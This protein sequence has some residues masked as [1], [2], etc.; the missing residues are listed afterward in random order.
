MGAL[1]RLREL[2]LELPE[3]PQALASYIPTRLVPIGDGRALLY[4]SGQVWLRDGTPVMTGR[5]PDEVSF[6]DACENARRCALN[7]LAQVHAAAGLDSVEAVAQVT[8]FV[9][10]ADDFGDQPRVINAASDLLHEVLGDAG[11]HTRMAVG[12]N[13]LP[14]RV[15]VELGGVVVVRQA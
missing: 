5:V 13:A 7:L 8:G 1:D 10:S 3:P 15:P 11:R 12:T 6:E 9:M 2:G 14:L 4:V